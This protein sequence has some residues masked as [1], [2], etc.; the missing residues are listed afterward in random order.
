MQVQVRAV[1][2]IEFHSE[3]ARYGS[4]TSDPET[5]GGYLHSW[6]LQSEVTPLTFPVS[7]MWAQ[8]PIHRESL[9][10]PFQIVLLTQTPKGG[11]LNGGKKEKLWQHLKFTYTY[12]S[13][14]WLT[15]P[16]KWLMQAVCLIWLHSLLL[17]LTIITALQLC[18]EAPAEIKA[19]FW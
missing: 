18:L 3:K 6:A 9:A 12:C 8:V 15:L 17:L 19:L 1:T 16:Q 5:H 13:V 10:G 2:E 7:G 14:E 11:F 4:F